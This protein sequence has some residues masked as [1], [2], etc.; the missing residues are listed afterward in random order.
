MV[1]ELDRNEPAYYG[2]CDSCEPKEQVPIMVE[3]IYDSVIEDHAETETAPGSY[4]KDAE[5]EKECEHQAQT[6]P[7]SGAD[8]EDYPLICWR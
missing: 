2:Q 6:D 4:N 1:K 7:D 5:L 3:L 8:T